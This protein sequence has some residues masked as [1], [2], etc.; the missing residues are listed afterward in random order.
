MLDR[1]AGTSNVI[2]TLSWDNKRS[3]PVTNMAELRVA[4]WN[5]TMWKDEGNTSTSGT[6]DSG[7]VSSATVNS[8]SPFTLASTTVSNAL[9]IRLVNFTANKCSNNVCLQWATASEVNVSHFEIEKSTNGRSFTNL[10]N[11]NARGTAQNNYGSLDN[12]PFRGK[13]YYRLKM[14]DVDGQFTYS[15][16]VLIDFAGSKLVSLF[17]NPAND[18]IKI[19]SDE[20]VQHIQIIDMSGRDVKQFLPSADNRYKIEDLQKGVYFIK[21]KPGTGIKTIKF[22]KL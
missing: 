5:G 12:N 20:V 18:F 6:N 9:P 3:G 8:F 19:Y 13:N 2:V 11:V 7:Y 17:P 16:V 15:S 1:T 14:V 21:L 4:R 10:E 22:T